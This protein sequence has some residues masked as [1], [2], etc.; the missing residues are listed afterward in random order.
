MD[1]RRLL[2][3][4]ALALLSAADAW[5]A[6]APLKSP[7][8]VGSAAGPDAIAVANRGALARSQ[9]ERFSGVLQ[10]F[11]Y[12]PGA[13]YEVWTAPL[14]VTTLSL[15]PGERVQSLAAGDT[16]RWQVGETTS[17]EGPSSQT[18]V[19]IKPLDAGLE[20]NLVITTSRRLYLVALKSAGADTFNAAVAWK[21]EPAAVST[22]ARAAAPPAR[23]AAP[24]PDDLAAYVVSSRGRRPAWTPTAVISDGTRT[25]IAFPPALS[26]GEA[27]LLF[28]LGPD[29]ARQMVN[30]RQRGDLFVVDQVLSRAELRLGVRRPQVVTITRTSGADK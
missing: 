12:A 27:P 23:A 25:L 16:L 5:S 8:P 18:H 14:R 15:L 30:Y 11:D 17:G 22:P 20:T 13:L 9:P 4:C 24:R 6:S 7:Q 28:A 3:A 1:A 2:T 26:R 29:G 21:P 19:L 10:V